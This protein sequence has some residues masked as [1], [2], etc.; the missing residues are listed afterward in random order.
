MSHKP[1]CIIW[2]PISHYFFGCD[3]LLCSYLPWTSHT[4]PRTSPYLTLFLKHCSQCSFLGFDM[5]LFSPT[6]NSLS[7]AG[8]LCL[9]LIFSKHLLKCHLLNEELPQLP[10]AQPPPWSFPPC[11]IPPSATGKGWGGNYFDSFSH[12]STNKY[13]AGRYSSVFSLLYPIPQ[14]PEVEFLSCNYSWMKE[15]CLTK[16]NTFLGKP[17]PRD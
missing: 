2:D 13:R 7:Q 5:G 3:V 11:N 9:L 14:C 4:R 15:S 17:P 8:H 16:V 12:S 10:H 6:K 1:L